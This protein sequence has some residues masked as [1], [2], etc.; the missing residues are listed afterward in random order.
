MKAELYMTEA[1]FCALVV[2]G[3]LNRPEKDAGKQHPEDVG[4]AFSAYVEAVADGMG[5]AI[6]RL[7]ERGRNR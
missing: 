4:A 2:R 3:F 7:S 6:W 5:L 1:E